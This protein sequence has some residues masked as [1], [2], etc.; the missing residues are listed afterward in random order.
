M[1]RKSCLEYGEFEIAGGSGWN[2]LTA[3]SP[4][5][6]VP[7]ST[8]ADLRVSETSHAWPVV[9][10]SFCRARSHHTCRFHFAVSER[11][12]CAGHRFV[13]IWLRK[14]WPCHRTSGDPLIELPVSL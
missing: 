9:L 12:S 7:P 1:R 4:I 8:S 6:D 5:L 3:H 11:L 10:W 2:V 13:S 14:I